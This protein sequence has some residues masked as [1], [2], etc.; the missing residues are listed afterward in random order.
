MNNPSKDRLL[1]LSPRAR[2]FVVPMLLIAALVI[3]VGS[4]VTR[5]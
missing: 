5:G 3:V 4:Y 2:R 1:G